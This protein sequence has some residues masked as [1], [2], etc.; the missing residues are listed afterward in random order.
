MPISDL[1]LTFD[2]IKVPSSD[3]NQAAGEFASGKDNCHVIVS[4]SDG[5]QSHNLRFDR[6]GDQFSLSVKQS[7]PAGETFN[8]QDQITW[9]VE[10]AASS[11]LILQTLRIM[12]ATL[13]TKGVRKPNAED[14]AVKATFPLVLAHYIVTGKAVFPRQ[15]GAKD[16]QDLAAV[17][18]DVF[19]TSDETSVQEFIGKIAFFQAD[20][21]LH[22]EA[23]SRAAWAVSILGLIPKYKKLMQSLLSEEQFDRLDLGDPAV[24][25]RLDS[26]QRFVAK[27]I[28]DLGMSRTLR[29]DSLTFEAADAYVALNAPNEKKRGFCEAL[30][31]GLVKF[32]QIDQ[33]KR[34]DFIEQCRGA[35]TLRRLPASQATLESLGIYLRSR[36]GQKAI[37]RE[38]QVEARRSRMSPDWLAGRGQIDGVS[39]LIVK[40]SR[41]KASYE[42]GT[43]P[44]KLKS[45]EILVDEAAL[46]TSLRLL[47]QSESKLKHREP[48]LAALG[49]LR[50][51]FGRSADRKAIEVFFDG[52]Y[53]EAKLRYS[54]DAIREILKTV[55][56]DLR[57]SFLKSDVAWPIAQSAVGGLGVAAL[58]VGAG[59]KSAPLPVRQGLFIGG[60]SAVGFALG[61][62]VQ[63]SK[64]A[65]NKHVWGAVGGAVGAAVLGGTCAALGTQTDMLRRKGGRMEMPMPD[66]PDRN[67]V[68][69]YGP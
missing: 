42:S 13:S 2:E 10:H 60:C 19:A 21:A 28:I 65:R 30:S 38:I 62:L 59:L 8:S 68:D 41:V 64:R 7:G 24:K 54:S 6:S 69:E 45:L 14:R 27:A 39:R 4:L 29:F 32:P 53:R 40:H 43:E 16:A 51:T 33:R 26:L 47:I 36:D 55:E 15:P 44:K 12:G 17:I 9:F 1:R 31:G 3:C 35:L 37:E 25:D 5:K 67:P 11:P 58:G 48:V 63:L 66:P 46:R 20:P 56:E 57:L 61:S 52:E 22:E 49:V 23:K 18:L 50:L 34:E